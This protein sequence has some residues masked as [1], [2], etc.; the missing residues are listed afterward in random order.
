M[1]GMVIKFSREHTYIYKVKC[2]KMCRSNSFLGITQLYF[3]LFPY[4]IVIVSNNIIIITI[5]L[6]T[7]YSEF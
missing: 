2:S 3:T 6:K 4:V 1:P 7:L 5:T